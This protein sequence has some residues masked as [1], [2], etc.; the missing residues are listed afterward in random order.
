[1]PIPMLPMTEQ[2][3]SSDTEAI[4]ESEVLRKEITSL[5]IV[6]P[7]LDHALDAVESGGESAL[8]IA[9]PVC[10]VDHTNGKEMMNSVIPCNIDQLFTMLFTNSKFYLDF[11]LS[12][13]TFG[14]FNSSS[15][16]F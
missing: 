15:S 16:Q 1:M 6:I 2:S 7:V 8:P 13:K 5:P 10:P 4:I 9:P 14:E 11:Q 3:D 12:R